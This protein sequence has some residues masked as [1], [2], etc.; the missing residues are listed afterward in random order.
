[1]PILSVVSQRIPERV[2][3][4]SIG[5]PLGS[6][7]RGA[8]WPDGAFDRQ[9]ARALRFHG[10][11]GRSAVMQ[12]VFAAVERFAPHARATLI[13]GET[14]TGKAALGR[15]LYQLG[16]RRHGAFVSLGGAAPV[17]SFE[18]H[19]GPDSTIYVDEVADLPIP[20]Q[21]ALAR[22]LEDDGRGPGEDPPPA[23]AAHVIAATSH[24]LRDAIRTG[25][26]KPELYYRLGV[27]E[28]HVPPL[29]ERLDDLPDL[30]T[31]FVHETSARLHLP[32]H[33]VSAG[34]ARLLQTLPWPGNL[35]ELR[36]V[37]ERACVLADG[38]LVGEAAV[39]AALAS[40]APAPVS[41]PITAA[42]EPRLRLDDAKRAHV[43]AV[44]D[45]VH[46]NK[47]LAAVRLGISRRA[48][49]RLLDALGA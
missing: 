10:L 25:N 47:S 41:L 7:G 45:G 13:T 19:A 18:E 29:R 33:S 21:A 22:A 11:I 3:G 32:A 8:G 27:F 15:I 26:F 38:A 48:L 9:P 43:R 12:T 40:A 34:A 14:G 44:L 1:L 2:D 17:E 37:I 30:A 4:P 42:P 35:R 6:S 16:P 39:R 36:N 20:A 31:A 49:Y 46:G 24:D 28:L 23:P 5:R